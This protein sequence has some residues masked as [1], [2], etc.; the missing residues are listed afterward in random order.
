MR[1][2]LLHVNGSL[3]LGARQRRLVFAYLHKAAIFACVKGE[4][5]PDAPECCP[6]GKAESDDI[7]AI[8]KEL[9]P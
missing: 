6:F 7:E 2:C 3:L 5:L 9:E 1:S 4:E 8:E